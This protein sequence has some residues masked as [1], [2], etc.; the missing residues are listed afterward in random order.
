MTNASGFPHLSEELDRATE[1]ALAAG[2]LLL[3]YD[4][5]GVEVEFKG[6]DDPVTRAD[7]EASHMIVTGLQGAFPNDAVLSE[8]APDDLARLGC[9]RVWIVDPMDGTREFIR[10]NGEYAVMIGLSIGGAARLGVVFQPRTG[11][12]YQGVVGHGAWMT[13]QGQRRSIEAGQRGAAADAAITLAV[14]RSHRSKRV[15]ELKKHLVVAGEV[16]SGSVGLKVGLVIRQVCDAYV[17]FDD[18]TKEWDT[19]GPQAILEAAGGTV[20]DLNGD[21]VIYNRKDLHNRTGLVA[22]NA[23]CH[24]RV[25]AAVQPVLKWHEAQLKDAPKA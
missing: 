8:E 4:R 14:S 16:V 15:D 18:R 1:L 17:I 6:P 24:A 9:E 10:K 11:Y 23:G 22:T 21:R 25:L 13:D 2:A 7:R 5:A 19:C 20:T 12:L 3:E